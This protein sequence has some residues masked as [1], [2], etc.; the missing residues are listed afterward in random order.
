MVNILSYENDIKEEE[1]DHEFME[2]EYIKKGKVVQII[3]GERFECKEGDFVFFY[4]G[5]KHSF[6]PIGTAGIVNVVFAPQLFEKMMMHRY[7]PINKRISSMVRLPKD[8][9]RRLVEIM[10]V[11]EHEYS[12]SKD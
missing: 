8:E 12:S 11:M 10:K 3:N 1:H 5:D 9:R 2:I 7:F 6:E 4:V